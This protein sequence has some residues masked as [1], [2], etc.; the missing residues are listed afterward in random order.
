MVSMR[1]KPFNIELKWQAPE[2]G[3]KHD[4]AKPRFSLIPHKALW[5]V[6]EVLEFGANRYGANNWCSVPNAR[7]RYFNAAHRHLNAWWGGEK[8][9]SESGLPH[10]AHAVCCLMFLMVFDGDNT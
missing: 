2:T 10:L 6:V 7:E 9:D 3:Q 1:H 5:Q 4:Q 8:V